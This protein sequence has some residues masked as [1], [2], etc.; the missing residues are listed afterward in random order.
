[1]SGLNS[2]LSINL[3]NFGNKILLQDISSG[4][5][6]LPQIIS[7]TTIPT[8]GNYAK[9][10][11]FMKEDAG[12]G[13]AA[14]YQNIGTTT[15]PNFS[16]VPTSGSGTATSLVDSN[17]ATAVS[18]GTTAAAVNNIKV[19]DAATGTSP[20]ITTEGSDA[21]VNMTFSTKSAGNGIVTFFNTAGQLALRAQ[22]PFNYIATET[23]AN[24]AIAGALLTSSGSNMPLAEGLR[25]VIKLAHTLQV[26][27]NTFSL[28][29][30]IATAIKSHLNI[31]NDIATAY[32]VGSVV[33]LM[34][35]GSVW[36][37]MSQ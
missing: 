22:Q 8:S 33:D 11:V 27:P 35:V 31:A 32:A 20:T 1:M 10:C 4:V 12:A 26:G 15:A 3:D 18:V 34:Y 16:L 36:Q 23:G 14:V 37:D 30:G 2:S 29:G 17:G 25:V 7:G 19:I 5:P 28:N 21:T 24:N 6:G 13:V 9:A